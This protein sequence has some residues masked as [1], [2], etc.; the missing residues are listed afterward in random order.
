DS[1]INH[2]FKQAVAPYLGI[3]RY[4]IIEE[5]KN[6][7]TAAEVFKMMLDNPED[8]ALMEKFLADNPERDIEHYLGLID[9]ILKNRWK[10]LLI[11]RRPRACLPSSGPASA[12]DETIRL[13]RKAAA[14]KGCPWDDFLCKEFQGLLQQYLEDLPAMDSQA[15]EEF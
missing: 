7:E 10:F 5:Y 13:A 2:I 11:Q 1:F 6:K 12:L 3:Y 14:A 15:K 4:T 8:F 9:E